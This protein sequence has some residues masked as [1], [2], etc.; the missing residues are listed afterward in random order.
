MAPS[1]AKA[2]DLPPP[3]RNST[4]AKITIGASTGR[5]DGAIISLIA[6]RVRMSTARA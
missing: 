4:A 1:A 3:G 5:S 2:L 6:A